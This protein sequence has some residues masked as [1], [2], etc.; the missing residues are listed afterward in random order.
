MRHADDIMSGGA[1]GGLVRE[2]GGCGMVRVFGVKEEET[3]RREQ[4]WSYA[5]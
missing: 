1:G 2:R 3:E 5:T 4:T